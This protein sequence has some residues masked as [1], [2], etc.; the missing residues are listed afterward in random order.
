MWR[1]GFEIIAEEKIRSAI[2]G[3]AFSGLAGEGKPLRATDDEYTGDNRM[4]F[5]VL[6]SNGF[7]PEWLELRKEIAER[8]DAVHAA[9]NDWDVAA[10]QWGVGHPLER[11]AG[12]L[13]RSAATTINGKIDLHN[14]RCPSIQLEIARFREDARPAS[15][16]T[17][18]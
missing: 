2:D 12:E 17:S 13:Y 14:L 4:A 8:R 1:M 16:T 7:L 6:R 3:G 15:V 5:N 9:M 18:S 10:R 11:H